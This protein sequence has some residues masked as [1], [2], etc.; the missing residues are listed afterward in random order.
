MFE[1]LRT[2]DAERNDSEHERPCGLRHGGL[3]WKAGGL[4]PWQAPD[5]ARFNLLPLLPAEETEGET[6]R[7]EGSG[8]SFSVRALARLHRHGGGARMDECRDA[9]IAMMQRRRRHVP[10]PGVNI[11]RVSSHASR[12]ARAQCCVASRYN[13]NAPSC[14]PL[15]MI[16]VGDSE[17]P[18]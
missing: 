13:P 9:S 1:A 5:E 15:I 12:Q 6:G 16:S 17:S 14:L 11:L 2:T 18:R 4:R 8:R 3:G 7:R 10:W